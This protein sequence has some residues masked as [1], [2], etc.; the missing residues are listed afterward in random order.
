MVVTWAIRTEGLTKR[1][2]QVV[3]LDGLDLKVGRGEIF[4]FLG[5]NGAGKSTTIRLLLALIRPTAG[6]AWIMDVPVGDVERAHHHVGY[7]AG[8]VA[9]W[10]QLTG[11]ETLTYLGN[12]SGHVDVPFRDELIERFRFD[13][14]KRARSYSKG[15]RQKLA[16]IAALMTRPDVLLLDEPTSGLDPLMEA[17]FQ[18]LARRPPAGG[19]RSSCPPTS[20]TRCRTSATGWRSSGRGGWS[21]SPRWR[22]CAVW[23]GRCWR[24]SSTARSRIWPG[25]RA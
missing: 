16:L 20:S 13:P 7:V 9:L 2:G 24:R 11:L 21:R 25:C 6:R 15:N 14:G 23:P 4:G 10:P 17:E 8:D 19:R 1:F 5:P 12:L 3:A 18:A 22:N